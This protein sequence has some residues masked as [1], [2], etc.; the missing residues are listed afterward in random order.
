MT[1]WPLHRARPQG[2]SVRRAAVANLDAALRV[3]TRIE[4]SRRSS[5]NRCR[6]DHDLRTMTRSKAMTLGLA[7]RG[8]CGRRHRAGGQP[9]S[10]STK[11]QLH[12]RG[13]FYASPAMNPDRRQDRGT[14]ETTTLELPE[15]WW[16]HY[17]A[18]CLARRG[19]GGEVKVGHPGRA[20][21]GATRGRTDLPAFAAKVEIVEAL[22]R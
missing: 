15:G 14:G 3:A 8:A 19:Y 6:L 18:L 13:A 22:G 17:L 10:S 21:H 1:I 4:R 16:H 12:L 5:R 7:H 20:G 11:S 9:P 2:L